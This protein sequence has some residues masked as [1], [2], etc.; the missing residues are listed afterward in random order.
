MPELIT[1]GFDVTAM[2]YGDIWFWFF[3]AA[4][5]ITGTSQLLGSRFP[6]VRK[7][8]IVVF[9]G[10]AVGVSLSPFVPAWATSLT[11]W[12]LGPIA[13]AVLLKE[14]LIDNLNKIVNA[15]GDAIA[16]K[17]TGGK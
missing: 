12:I 13:V 9:C 3:T 8:W 17:I 11:Q 10:T 4:I 15:V 1:R 7:F 5:V 16:G 2:S 6:N 14:T